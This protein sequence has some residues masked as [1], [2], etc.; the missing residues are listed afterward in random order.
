[1]PHHWVEWDMWDGR[2]RRYAI[3]EKKIVFEKNKKNGTVNVFQAT[4]TM[5][6][7][8]EK[9]IEKWNQ[10]HGV[11]DKDEPWKPEVKILDTVSSRSKMFEIIGKDGEL[12][13]FGKTQFEITFL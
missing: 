6:D 3:L 4:K 2:T 11:Y 10:I 5:L 1:M 13:S 8:M 9:D 7:L 12:I